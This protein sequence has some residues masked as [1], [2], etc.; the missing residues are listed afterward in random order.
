[1]NYNMHRFCAFCGAA[2]LSAALIGCSSSAGKTENTDNSGNSGFTNLSAETTDSL[3]T[4]RDLDSSYEEASAVKIQLA[5]DASSCEASSVTIEENTITITEEG[6]YLLSG[7]LSDGQVVVNVDASEKVQ[8]VL[9]GAAITNSSSAGIYV[10]QADKVFLTLAPDSENSV[11]T[12]GEFAAIDDNNI[13]AAIFSKDDLTINGS[14]ALTVSCAYG[15]GIVSKDDLV[16]ADGTY[17]IKAASHAV[18]GKESIRIADGEFSLSA[19]KDG[20]HS[21]GMFYLADGS[22]TIDTCKEGI[23]G[24]TITIDGG[25]VSLRAS[26]D[27]LNASNASSTN[28]DPMAADS[29]CMITINGGSLFID[30]D[31]DGIDSNGGLLI[32]GGETYVSGPSNDGNSALDYAGNAAI[33]GGIF[34][35]SGY[36]GMAQNFGSDSTQASML[37]SFS[38]VSSETISLLDSEGQELLSYSPEKSYNC[39]VLSCPQITSSGTYTVTSGTES[40]S[41]TM[42][43]QI[44]GTSGNGGMRGNKGTLPEQGGSMQPPSGQDGSMQPP[45]GQDGSMQPP[46]GQDGS[47]QF[48]RERGGSMQPPSGQDGSMQSPSGQDGSMQSPSEQGGSMQPP[49]SL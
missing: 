1:M 15:H 3:F 27:G 11:S 10:L 2:V 13:D 19:G 16:F 40:V 48:P 14:G 39:V 47:M 43:G 28:A 6:T 33:S 49:S 34:A 8:L 26:D 12:T 45:S 35:A 25:S 20:L 23:E 18:S 37:V 17:R 30:A 22:I 36:S 21:D 4:D 46:S 24:L 5:D 38:S 41:V 29:S 31:G 32:T 44:Y 7:T 9:N 42:S